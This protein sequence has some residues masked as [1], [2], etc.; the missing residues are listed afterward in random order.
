MKAL[1]HLCA[2]AIALLASDAHPA[3]V[4]FA[5]GAK[6]NYQGNTSI[7]VGNPSDGF[8]VTCTR[9]E[10][11]CTAWG[12]R[13][14]RI[15]VTSGSAFFSLRFEIKAEKTEWTQP[16]S[17]G[18]IW[19]NAIRWLNA[20]GDVISR[21]L[22]NVE[23]KAGAFERFVFS[24]E[25]PLGA[26]FVDISFGVDSKPTVLPDER[27]EV[28]NVAFDVFP[29]GMK[30][31]K[32]RKPDLRP[33]VVTSRFVS[34]SA[35]AN[36]AVRYEITDD[37]AVDWSVVSVTDR[38]SSVAI[39]FSR[40]GNIISLAPGGPWTPGVHRLAVAVKDTLGNAEVSEKVFLIGEDP[41]PRRVAL[42]DDGI[43]L[44]DGK[45]FYPVGIYGIKPHEFNSN[46]FDKAVGDLVVAGFNA[47]HSY[48]YRWDPTFLSAAEK[49]GMKL[50][51]DGKCALAKSDFFVDA[52][53]H[54]P[55]TIAW[56]IGD[57]TSMNTTPGRLND[58]DEACRMLDGTRLT[59]H[60][61]GVRSRAAK[62]NL[63]EYVNYA[64]VFLAEIYP[65]DNFH[66]ERCVAEVCRDMDRCW[67]DI[68][69]FGDGRRKCGVWAILQCFHGK[70]WLR[71]PTPQEMY[72]TSF[73]A[74]IHGATGMTWFHYDGS[75]KDPKKYY[76]G[77]FRTQED[78]SAMTNIAHRIAALAPVLLERTPT[79]PP[80][81]EIIFGPKTDDFGQPT[82]S[83][84]MKVH[85]SWV[86]LLAVNAKTERVRA[87]F[88]MNMRT[89]VGKVA[90]EHR[91]VTLA[92]GE[93]ED[94]FEP[95]GVHVYRFK[96]H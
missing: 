64:D 63:E 5:D 90:W 24:G 4:S 72:A 42:R 58:R 73:A 32:E 75:T 39:P 82:V 91:D 87:K 21:R 85:G 2:S 62:S 1:W 6:S 54:D 96:H 13:S 26:A 80:V 79:Q 93:F 11:C 61:D 53:R 78:W 59:C 60:A 66:D 84:L 89:S 35:N 27:I 83:A 12:C 74:V 76:S 56:Y 47:G 57:D 38:V 36:I 25:V 86:Y 20:S 8:V 7:V 50:W 23:F 14:E 10:P 88:R 51:T 77:M 65:I 16:D 28:R 43:A 40:D 49:N 94:D 19:C 55:S 18:K 68:R 52:L 9:A 48:Q 71:Y 92:Q 69:R 31:P 41:R 34:P 46:N 67:A 29:G 17:A 81:P 15:A 70:S 45:P 33:P 3:V 30:P 22:L 95:L 44:V 37:T